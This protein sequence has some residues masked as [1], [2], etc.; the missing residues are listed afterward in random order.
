MFY[1]D[2]VTVV[3]FG[4]FSAVDPSGE[5]TR[6]TAV[7]LATGP[8]HSATGG[9]P[10]AAARFRQSA[11]ESE[12][13]ATG[14]S[15]PYER[16]LASSLATHVGWEPPDQ[17]TRSR[18]NLTA[19]VRWFPASAGGK[20]IHELGVIYPCVS[21]GQIYPGVS[22][23]NIYPCVSWGNISMCELGQYI[24]VSWGNIYPCVS[25][26][27]IYPSVRWDNISPCVSWGQYIHVS[28]GNIY[29]CV[30]WGNIY[31]CVRWGN[32]YPCVS[33]GQYISMC[34]L[35]QYIHVSWGNISM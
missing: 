12:S 17:R 32:I 20:Y 24:H 28:W 8:W 27:N 23:G 15:S 22:W 2:I 7:A 11:P 6:V 13:S 26:G 1:V 4:V 14:R 18:E 16:P 33:W 35:G 29:P 5:S 10:S 30:S 34:E 25:W 3:L 31:P 9:G 21:W 19:L